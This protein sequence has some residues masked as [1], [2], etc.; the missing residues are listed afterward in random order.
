MQGWCTCENVVA[1]PKMVQGVGRY[2]LCSRASD[3][4]ITDYPLAFFVSAKLYVLVGGFRVTDN[5]DLA[6]GTI[7]T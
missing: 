2:L 4:T 5:F 1:C 7:R 6:A 3:K